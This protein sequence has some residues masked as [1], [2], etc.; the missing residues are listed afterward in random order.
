MT[1]SGGASAAAGWYPDPSDPYT[2][3]YWD[4]TQWTAHTAPTGGAAPGA[5][6]PKKRL[7]GGAIAAII[8]GA[9]VA[10]LA[11]FGLVVSILGPAWTNERATIA[12]SQA[13]VD[14]STLGKEIAT[15]YVDNDG[16]VPPIVVDEGVY[17]LA[18]TP[19]AYVSDGVEFG[20]ASG[21]G[22]FD[23]CVWVTS[24]TGEY[25]DYQY[26]AEGGLEQGR[27]N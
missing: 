10:C 15:W 1:T 21:T 16:P 17:I 12:D 23:W 25:Q 9:V 2:L 22:A 4:G 27:C 3:R 26:S 8:V 14:A 7:S 19:V 24:P 6:A 13:K 18:G 11:I 20:D 5:G